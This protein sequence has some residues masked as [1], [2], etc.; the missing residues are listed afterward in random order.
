MAELVDR[1]QR[2]AQQLLATQLPRRWAHTC[3]VVG[4]A[5]KL[6][7]GLGMN[8]SDCEA[9]VAAAW[10]HDCGYAPTLVRTRLHPVDGADYLTRQGFP[11]EVVALVAYHTGA[12]WEARERGLAEELARYR[13][14][15]RALLNVLSC[16]DLSAGPSGELVSPRSRVEEVLQRYGPHDPVHRALCSSGPI[17]ISAAEQVL[18][19]VVNGGGLGAVVSPG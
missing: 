7:R 15:C 19:A 11:E 6:C 13:P 9:V 1:A 12:A 14:P 3:A 2:C 16:A 5:D 10:V 17:L 18:A 8:V 4:E